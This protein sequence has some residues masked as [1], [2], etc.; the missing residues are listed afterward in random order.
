MSAGTE[1]LEYGALDQLNCL[2]YIPPG[3]KFV[4]AR[5]DIEGVGSVEIGVKGQER[6]EVV[7]HEGGTVFFLKE[8]GKASSE[9]VPAHWPFVF[10][11][12]SFVTLSPHDIQ[13]LKIDNDDAPAQSADWPKVA[14]YLKCPVCRKQAEAD[15]KT[16]YVLTGTQG[17]RMGISAQ[18]AAKL[19]WRFFCVECFDSL[20]SQNLYIPQEGFS[21][22]DM[23]SSVVPF[24][25]QGVAAPF[26]T[27]GYH[28]TPGNLYAPPGES[29]VPA[30]QRVKSFIASGFHYCLSSDY[31]RYLTLMMGGNRSKTGAA[32]SGQTPTI[33]SKCKRR[34]L[35]PVILQP[36]CSIHTAPYIQSYMYQ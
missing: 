15:G 7:S 32:V 4:W 9:D 35:Y 26:S 29:A 30:Y 27:M 3:V 5:R 12:P 10:M 33:S 1:A 31:N 28:I 34:E 18:M 23:P 17:L 20:G 6:G 14:E 22:A 25:E 16:T 21:L 13:E 36:Y 2:W 19:L 11:A 24:L 8:D